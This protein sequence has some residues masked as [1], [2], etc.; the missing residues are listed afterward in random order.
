MR[1][2]TNANR[3]CYGTALFVTFSPKESDSS[4]TARFVRARQSDPAVIADGSAKFQQRTVPA[5]D[6]DYV[7][8]S[9]EALAE[10]L[11]FF[12]ILKF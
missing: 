10:E 11:V 2:Q 5:L 8:L 7:N 12:C 4:L 3:V 9:P 1:H 6:V